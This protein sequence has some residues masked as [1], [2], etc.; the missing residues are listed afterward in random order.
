MAPAGRKRGDHLGAL[1]FSECQLPHGRPDAAEWAVFMCVPLVVPLCHSHSQI[2]GIPRSAGGQGSC[3]GHLCVLTRR[4]LDTSWKNWNPHRSPGV[5]LRSAGQKPRAV[6]DATKR[7][8]PAA[9]SRLP[10]PPAS[11][12]SGCESTLQSEDREVTFLDPSASWGKPHLPSHNGPHSKGS[13]VEVAEKT[14]S[15]GFHA[16]TLP[17]VAPGLALPPSRLRSKWLWGW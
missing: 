1:T 13:L 2:P 12:E 7:L 16:G 11:P 6:G 9:G 3:L 5:P 8:S 15:A 10:C 17:S 4:Q 14:E